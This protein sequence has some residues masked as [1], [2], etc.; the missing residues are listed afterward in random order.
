M[1]TYTPWDLSGFA[2]TSGKNGLVVLVT[3]TSRQT[4]WMIGTGLLFAIWIVFFF[5]QKNRGT[6]TL[7]AAMSSSFLCTIISILFYAI[8]ALNPA[9]L[10][11]FIMLTPITVAMKFLQG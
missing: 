10:V 11:L 5:A 7:D 1:V 6:L 2:N 4:Q 3:E 9:M 8:G